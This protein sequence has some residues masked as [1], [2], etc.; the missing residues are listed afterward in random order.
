MFLIE[1][2][3]PIR[4]GVR[5]ILDNFNMKETLENMKIGDSFLLS[6]EF[7]KRQG[8]KFPPITF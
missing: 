4:S 7:L 3:I 5:S 1:K 6:R 8:D 2:D